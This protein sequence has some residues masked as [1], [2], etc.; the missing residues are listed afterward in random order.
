MKQFYFRLL[1]TIIISS[2][3]FTTKNA[4]S[5]NPTTIASSSNVSVVENFN[6]GHGSFSSSSLYSNSD[7]V[8]FY[9]IAS[10]GAWLENSGLAIRD[11]SIISSVYLNNQLSGGISIGFSFEAPAGTQYRIRIINAL[12][13]CTGG[14]TLAG[15]TANGP[16]WTILPSVSG[17]LKL[18][19][20]D[21]DLY[22]GQNLRFEISFRANSFGNILFDNFALGEIAA[23]PLPV[24]FKSIFAQQV[25]SA[26]RLVWDVAD[27]TDVR[28]YEVERSTN[29][30][31]FN[32]IGFVNANGK[33]AA[34]MFA[35]NEIMSNT[36]YYRVKNVDIDGKFKY[37]GVVKVTNKLA[38]TLKLFPLPAQNTVTLQHSKL[39]EGSNMFITTVDG[40]TV[41]QFN[42]AVGSFQTKLDLTGL[43]PGMYIIRLN[44]GNES[45]QS[46]KL[47]KQ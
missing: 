5:Q 15:T 36:V 28:G 26:T 46:I 9:Y 7:D 39:G 4:S 42:S 41:K 40:R 11:A 17:I 23:S 30:V 2:V 34:Y 8:S 24:T 3:L 45:I 32:T 35:D 21:G 1:K 27:E 31:Q 20:N 13:N 33:S 37:S 10:S 6:S 12:C 43:N 14:A 18:K 29:G 44:D 38:S 16:V 22:Q 19:L 25:N 47:I